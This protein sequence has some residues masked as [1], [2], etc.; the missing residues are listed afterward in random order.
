MADDILIDL[1]TAIYPWAEHAETDCQH[2]LDYLPDTAHETYCWSCARALRGFEL[3]H[4]HDNGHQMIDGGSWASRESD[5]CMHCD[6]CGI[7]LEYTLTEHG[8]EREMEH[9]RECPCLRLTPGEAYHLHAMIEAGAWCDDEDGRMAA[10]VAGWLA[11]AFVPMLPT[12]EKTH[13]R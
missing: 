8:F 7:I 2:W 3:P 6:R 4:D 9:Y 1:A 13:G 11:L 10:F 5:T 12:A